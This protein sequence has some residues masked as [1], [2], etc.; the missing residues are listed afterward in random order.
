M[1][2]SEPRADGRE[3]PDSEAPTG[4]MPVAMLFDRLVPDG[5]VSMFNRV[6]AAV[7]AELADKVT[8]FRA[9]NIAVL[10]PEQRVTYDAFAFEYR[11][12]AGALRGEEQP[13]AA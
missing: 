2:A 3:P 6:L 4:P 8:E 11:Q 1:S 13:A 5:D 9:A 10:A 12:I 7:N